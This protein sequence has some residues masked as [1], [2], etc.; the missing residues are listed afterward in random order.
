MS[1]HLKHLQG[2]SKRILASVLVGCSLV[3]FAGQHLYAMTSKDINDVLNSW[4]FY[5]K[6]AKEPICATGQG[7]GVNV[8]GVA[9]GSKIYMIGDSLTVNSLSEIQTAF[10]AAGFVT[11]KINA[12]S[13]RAILTDTSPPGTS[14]LD[15]ARTD[16]GSI[17]GADVVVVA[18]GTNSGVEDLNV[19][20]P[21]LTSEI[22]RSK[23]GIPIYWVNLFYTKDGGPAARNAIITDQA[24]PSKANY[25]V[26]DTTTAGIEL[27]TDGT[28][29]TTAGEKKFADTIV[30]GLQSGA[31]APPSGVDESLNDIPEDGNPRHILT[32]PRITDEAAAARAIDDYIR[33]SWPTSPFVG[34]GKYFI[35]GAK[36]SNVNPFLAVGHLQQEN[37]F[38]T[39]PRGWHAMNPPT[40]NAFGATTSQQPYVIYHGSAND[41]KVL[42][43]P[44]WEGSLDSTIENTREDFF[45]AIRRK[46]LNHGSVYESHDFATYIH[47]YAPSS[48]PANDE[49]RYIRNIFA[50]IDAVTAGLTF[51]PS[52]G[53]A[54]ALCTANL[55]GG[56]NGGAVSIDGYSFPLA[57]QTQAVGGITIGQTTTTH[58]DRTPA[59]DLFSTD[60]ATVY[61]L[62]GGTPVTINTNLGGQ[63]GCSSIQFKADDGYYYWYGHM[64]D[65]VVTENVHVAAGTVL[66]KIADARNYTSRCWGG[67]PHLHIDRG[68]SLPGPDGVMVPQRGGSDDCRDPAFIPFLSKLYES[69]PR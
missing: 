44:S 8:V 33:A 11:T 65:V 31:T 20:I 17:Q 66:G 2:K 14:G 10:T 19:Q 43:W 4:A 48:D 54:T 60:S 24:S 9:S 67:G 34:L 6:T 21:A 40:Y 58:H 69:L 62:Y 63:A 47:H 46:Y 61:A 3:T 27:G 51:G 45:A 55:S 29:P 41:Y 32:Y 30:A 12:D 57:P 13:G 28:H 5:D 1:L 64:K 39:A 38:A 59:F 15:A 35:S 49:Q 56:A 25:N 68:C 7:D 50:T 53:A 22:R 26:I 52:N 16:T 23:P 18:L 42:I 36:R 37:G